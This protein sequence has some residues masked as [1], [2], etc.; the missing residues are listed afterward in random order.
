MGKHIIIIDDDEHI[1]NAFSLSLEDTD[2]IVDKAESGALGLELV[3]KT[4][5]DL[6]YL[7]LKMPG[8][9]GIE[10]LKAIRKLNP[11]LPVYIITA[12]HLEFMDDLK[13]VQRQGCDFELLSKP[14]EIDEIKYITYS[15][16]QI[17]DK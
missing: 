6:V 7:D 9:S 5:Y 8:M 16:L 1:R 10:T 3:Q 4:H 2:I 15:I 12:F 11:S 13:E 14:I 17:S